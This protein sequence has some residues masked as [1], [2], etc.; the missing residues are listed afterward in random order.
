MGQP[1]YVADLVYGVEKHLILR[2][3]IAR[4]EGDPALKTVAVG[5]LGTRAHANTPVEKRRRSVEQLHGAVIVVINFVPFQIKDAAP[6]LERFFEL[7]RESF[8]GS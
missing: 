2:K 6:E 8:V 3:L 5:E 4:V 7:I 1:K